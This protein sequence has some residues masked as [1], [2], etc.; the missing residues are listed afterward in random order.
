MRLLLPGACLLALAACASPSAGAHQAPEPGATPVAATAAPGAPGAPGSAATTACTSPEGF[1]LDH[2]AGWVSNE[3]GVLP[4]CS[5]FGPEEF[6]VPEASDVRTAPITV[7]VVPVPF[8]EAGGLPEEV[9]ARSGH[10]VDGRAAVREELVTAGGLY[11]VGTPVTRWTVDFGT[12]TLVAE[13]VGLHP[14][15]HARD[16]AVLDEMIRT[17]RVGG[18]TRA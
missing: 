9:R 8:V 14:A 10:V 1:G 6:A 17:L 2:P 7:Q 12:E 5:W 13:T 4:A 16:V 3:V 11:P 18:A 15:E